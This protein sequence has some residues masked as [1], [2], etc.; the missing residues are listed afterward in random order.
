MDRYGSLL[1]GAT[2]PQTGFEPGLAPCFSEF[3][4]NFTM[5]NKTSYTSTNQIHY[6][7]KVP[8]HAETMFK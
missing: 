7:Y 8:V 5:R 2:A 4:L 1:V 3:N 6:V